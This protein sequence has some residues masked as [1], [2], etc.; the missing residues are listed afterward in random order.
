MYKSYMRWTAGLAELSLESSVPSDASIHGM[1]S[2]SHDA[3]MAAHQCSSMQQAGDQ[4]PSA[5]IRKGSHD[6]PWLLPFTDMFSKRRKF[7]VDGLGRVHLIV[8]KLCLHY[9]N[10]LHSKTVLK[11]CKHFWVF[12]HL[13]S[14]F[15]L[16]TGVSV[17]SVPS[18]KDVV[19]LQADL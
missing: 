6:L 7:A 16:G 11:L 1:Q 2:I 13:F 5:T 17:H 15:V 18:F 19:S 3:D 9:C 8:G 10:A 14:I 4:A 12:K